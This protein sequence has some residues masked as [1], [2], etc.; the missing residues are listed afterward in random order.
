MPLWIVMPDELTEEDM[1]RVWTTKEIHEKK[2]IPEAFCLI[3]VPP[4][5]IFDAFP[6]PVTSPELIACKW[7][8]EV[9]GQE[10]Y[11]IHKLPY[12]AQ[13]AYDYKTCKPIPS[14]EGMFFCMFPDQC[15]G[16]T[17]C[18]RSPACTE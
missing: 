11:E 14:T 6:L 1:N 7:A 15:K 13:P 16:R 12:S 8:E 17:A 10:P 18:P 9:F 5:E 2:F 4:E 3:G